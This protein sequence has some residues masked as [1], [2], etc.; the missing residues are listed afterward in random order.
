MRSFYHNGTQLYT[1]PFFPTA[2]SQTHLL[3]D[4]REIDK[5]SGCPLGVNTS[6]WVVDCSRAWG[7][8]QDDFNIQVTNTFV[9][10]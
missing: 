5:S 1:L 3:F 2:L 4:I 9:N 8:L 10:I 7:N 6:N